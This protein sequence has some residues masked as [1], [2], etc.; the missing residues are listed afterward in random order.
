MAQSSEWTRLL[1]GVLLVFGLN[2]AAIVVFFLLSTAVVGLRTVMP[3]SIRPFFD[4]LNALIFMCIAG[5]GLSQFLYVIPTIVVLA[6]NQQH[7]LM[8]GIVIGAAITALLNAG[9]FIWLNS[10]FR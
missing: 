8:K 1:K 10:Q 4:A 9:C 5:I 2:V 6:R 7:A 3:D